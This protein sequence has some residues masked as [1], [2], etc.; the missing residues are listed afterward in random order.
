MEK[1]TVAVST[2][3]GDGWID[4]GSGTYVRE[5]KL[6]SS[7]EFTNQINDGSVI[8]IDGF[9]QVIGASIIRDLGDPTDE[10]YIDLDPATNAAKGFLWYRPALVDN[11]ITLE[12]VLEDLFT[13][14]GDYTI[15]S[16][17]F[18][19]NEGTLPTSDP[20]NAAVAGFDELVIWQKSDVIFSRAFSNAI[21][22]ETTRK[23]FL[24]QLKRVFQVDWDIDED[25]GELIIEH[26]SEFIGTNGLDLTLAPYSEQIEKYG[27]YN[28]EEARVP[29]KERFEWMDKNIV[30]DFFKGSPILYSESCANDGPKALK[31]DQTTTD[32]TALISYPDKADPDGLFFGAMK[33]DGSSYYF[34]IEDDYINGHLAL[35]NL[36]PNYW[37]FERFYPVGNLNGIDVTFDSYILFKEQ[38]ELEV[39]ISL[40]DFL[41]FD[42]AKKVNTQLGWGRV[43]SAS[44][45]FRKS[46]LLLKI[47]HEL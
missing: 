22:A 29:S 43:V 33:I 24:D 13:C 19:I 42:P 17:F 39:K 30:S 2:P 20:Y 23:D 4:L 28:Y 44:Y 15:R 5:P 12:D 9:K 37:T 26:V 27:D 41:S 7:I 21:R 11:G 34:G 31:I 32:F 25:T 8:L 6:S 10:G 40:A 46:T 18:R 3:F 16:N 38:E 14:S 36:H 45:S 1:V 47:R 35:T